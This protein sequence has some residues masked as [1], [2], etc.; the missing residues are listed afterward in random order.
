MIVL[1]DLDSTLVRFEGFDEIAR[2]KG[3]Y[4]KVSEITMRTMNGEI[5]FASA[6]A[7]KLALLAPSK[8]DAKWLVELCGKHIEEGMLDTIAELKNSKD[9]KIGILSNGLDIVVKEFGEEHGFNT[10]YCIGVRAMFDENGDYM[11][12]DPSD[13]LTTDGGKAE[14][15]K[16]LKNKNNNKIIFVGDSAGDMEAGKYADLFI[17]YGGIIEREKV[18]LGSSYFAHNMNDVLRIIKRKY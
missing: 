17:G 16:K 5:P 4:D 3:I 7:E 10:N 14:I 12:L 6:F 15:I 11:G 2:R 9:T 8:S 18:I 13:P 1:F